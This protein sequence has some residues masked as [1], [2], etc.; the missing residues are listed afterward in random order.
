MSFRFGPRAG[1]CLGLGDCFVPVILRRFV[2]WSLMARSISVDSEPTASIYYGCSFGVRRVSGLPDF[3]DLKSFGPGSPKPFWSAADWPPKDFLKRAPEHRQ[4]FSAA[5]PADPA[6]A[7]LHHS[8]APSKEI[9]DPYT[10]Y[11]SSKVDSNLKFWGDPLFIRHYRLFAGPGVRYDHHLR[12]YNGHKLAVCRVSS[13]ESSHRMTA[14]RLYHRLPP[15]ALTCFRCLL[16]LHFVLIANLF[17]FLK[18]CRR[19]D[20]WRY[21]LV[22]DGRFWLPKGPK[23][24][25][26][27]YF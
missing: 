23:R 27:S 21:Q 3:F 10:E 26:R 9:N 20:S 16:G 11:S 15:L 12:S 19:S 18:C 5:K 1:S 2:V 13:T 8:E 4:P 24:H 17:H 25:Q 14:L 22:L 7:V 6:Q